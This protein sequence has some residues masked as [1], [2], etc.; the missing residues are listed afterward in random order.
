[1][2]FGIFHFILGGLSANFD[3][4]AKMVMMFGSAFLLTLRNSG[5][6]C[7]TSVVTQSKFN[8]V[9]S[10]VLSILLTPTKHPISPPTIHAF[11]SVSPPC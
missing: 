8:K 11:V 9:L 5:L 10:I 7:P 3:C 6:L 4:V 2:I 1:M